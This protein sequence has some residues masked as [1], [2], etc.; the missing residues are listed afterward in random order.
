[1]EELFWNWN[2]ELDGIK[3]GSDS[4]RERDA[5]LERNVT[6]RWMVGG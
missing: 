2:G 1:M 3:L 6:V 4:G 5:M